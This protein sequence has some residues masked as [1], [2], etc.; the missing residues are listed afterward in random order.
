MEAY[1]RTLKIM[2]K[3][4]LMLFLTLFVAS[5]PALISCKKSPSTDDTS[6]VGAH[7]NDADRPLPYT[8]ADWMAG[9]DD[10]RYISELSIP[11]THDCGADLH[12][13]E[14]GA[15]WANVIAQ[16]FRLSNQMLLGVRWFDVRLSDDAGTMTVYHW[17]YYLHKNFTD[18]ITQAIGFLNA[19][20][21]ET[22]VFMIKQEHSTRGDDAFANGIWC[23]YL[24]PYLSHF[25]LENHIPQLGEVRGKIVIMRQFEGTHG[26]PMGSPLIWQENST[27]N[28]YMSD[29]N[30]YFYV[31]D[32]YSLGTV[33]IS[34][35]ISEIESCIEKA[36]A[37]P[38]PYRCLYI[39]FTSAE[40]QGSQ[41][42]E[43]ISSEITPAIDTY[44]QSKN[45]QNVGVIMVN[46]AGGSDD[47]EVHTGFV[48]TIL[49][50]NNFSNTLQIGTQCWMNHNLR[51]TTYSNGDAIPQV[52]D[53]AKWD[54]LTTGAWCY[55]NNDST[56]EVFD[57]KLYNWYAV[58][59]KRG[60][61]PQGW[62]VARTGE[63]DTLISYA[64]GS[65]VAAGKL[66]DAGTL[67]WMSPNTGGMND[68]LFT[69]TPAGARWGSTFG[70]NGITALFWTST[71]SGTNDA[72]CIWMNFDNPAVQIQTYPRINGFSVRCVKN[73]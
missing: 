67:H 37:E 5:G 2:K 52:Q 42:L 51:V 49:N 69:A 25:W 18:L 40:R 36:H 19:H 35:K 73:N 30:F 46:F 45:Y 12:T 53:A 10:S 15:A 68:Y 56:H 26:Y 66:K 71:D 44:L 13:S 27:G 21:T 31:Q 8:N 20:P 55:Y 54:T 58:H 64:G 70:S 65:T 57:G 43:H 23:G 24:Y 62:H 41:T 9:I 4:I 50:L 34:T 60:L 72:S 48:Q 39:N 63:W 38:Y 7:P 11:G 29:N 33:E 59:D 47:D 32:H 22:V 61:A 3:R 1:H 14:Q 16:D 17:N 6:V 28:M